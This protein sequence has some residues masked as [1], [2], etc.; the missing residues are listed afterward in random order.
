M[1]I[2]LAGKEDVR[3]L[4]SH[5]ICKKLRFEEDK[6]K[7]VVRIIP[8]ELL[9]EPE[10]FI[11][12]AEVVRSLGGDFVRGR[13]PGDMGHFIVPCLSDKQ[14]KRTEFILNSPLVDP[15]RRDLDKAILPSSVKNALWKDYVEHWKRRGLL[16]D[17]D[18]ELLWKVAFL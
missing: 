14:K 11:P 17:Q 5:E 4:F 18:M 1:L 10:H 16:T 6:Q 3:K 7:C 13:K 15:L 9:P 12:I 8:R 2:V